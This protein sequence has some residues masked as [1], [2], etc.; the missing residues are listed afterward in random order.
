MSASSNDS[1]TVLGIERFGVH[2]R[3]QSKLSAAPGR[4]EVLKPA[5]DGSTDTAACR[6]RMDVDRPKLL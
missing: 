5:Q 2:R 4:G 1:V 6:A 3:V